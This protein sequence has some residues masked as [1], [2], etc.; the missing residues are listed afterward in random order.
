MFGNNLFLQAAAYSGAA[1]LIILIS[2]W[3]LYL[4]PI[5][6][7]RGEAEL[8]SP[9]LA[10]WL[11]GLL[12]VASLMWVVGALWDASMHIK[13]GEIPAGADFLWP[14]HL[15]LYGGFLL[16]FLVAVLVVGVIAAKGWRKGVHDPRRWVR[17]NPYLGAV[18][19]ASLYEMMAIP[20]DA[21]WH[22]IFGR[23]LTAWSP[24]HVMIGLMIALVITSTIGVLIQSFPGER[25]AGRR[26]AAIIILLG[27]ML[28]TIYII[29]VLEWEL[30]VHSTIVA[31]RPIWYYPLVGGS[32]AFFTLALAKWL[33]R[34]RWSATA[35]AIAFYLVRL[36]VSLGLHLSGNITPALPLV[37]ILGAIFMD[38]LPLQQISSTALRWLVT[39]AAF[40]VG[41]ALLAL[42]LL[43]MRASIPAL[44]SGDFTY[45]IAGTLL[46]ALLLLPAARIS[47]RRLLGKRAQV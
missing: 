7:S 47:A 28:N 38:L 4:S 2:T 43:G 31:G 12:I 32:L 23:D 3:W 18:A 26:D 13:T 45:T 8:P 44:N 41:F 9:R 35:A 6:T 25:R 11:A 21:L 39:A 37:F 14:P 34:W 10:G 27:L 22:E 29:G 1:A 40:T 20:G 42:P 30:P 16:A 36:P 33:V 5:K 17:Q 19:L 46:A 24:P 15:V